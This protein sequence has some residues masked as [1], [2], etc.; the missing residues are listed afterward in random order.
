MKNSKIEFCLMGISQIKK[1][2][3][4]LPLDEST[5]YRNLVEGNMVKISIG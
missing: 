5:Y 2:F 3:I 1:A 4:K